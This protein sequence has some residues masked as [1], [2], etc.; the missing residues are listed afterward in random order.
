MESDCNT[1]LLEDGIAIIGMACRFPGAKDYNQ[2][3]Q[4]LEQGVNSISEVPSWRWEVEKHYSPDPHEQNK[5]ISKWGG[6]VE[7]IEKFDAEFFG[8]S[9]REAERVDPQHR[10]MLELSWSCIE[11][12]GYSPSQLSGS[13]VGV[14]IGACNYDSILL[15]NQDRENIQG[16]SGTG[17]WT[18]MIPNRISS[19][20][21]FH[22]PSVPIDTAC[23]SSLVAAHYAINAI[24]E[25]ECDVALV[26]GISVLFT[27][28][29]YVQ[30]SKLGMLSPTG[31]CRT[32]DSEADGYVRGEGAGMILLKPLR[33]AIEDGDRI[34]GT[35][36]GSAVNHGGKARTL[37]APNVYA[38]AQVLRTAYSRANISP[39]TVS[40]IESHGTGTPLGDPIE[41]NA[42]K[43]SFRQLYQQYELP[44]TEKAYCA[45][46]AVKSNI[47]HL[48]GASGIAGL[49]KILLAMQHKKLPK[50]VNYKKLNPRINLKDSPFYI[51]DE[52]QEWERLTTESGEE[53]P[54]R[55]G[56]SSFGIGG[57]NAH[58]IL[59]EAP[60][61]VRS[62]KS[63]VR[64]KKNE[65]QRQKVKRKEEIEPPLHILGLSANTEQAL[66]D[67]VVNYR[68]C[69]KTNSELEIEDICYTANT[70]RTH[71]FTA[72]L[73][74]VAETKLEL[75]EKLAAFLQEKEI[76]GTYKK[77]IQGQKPTKIAFMFTGQG[78]Q[79]TNMGASLYKTQPI[80]RQT[81][82]RCNEILKD[83]LELPL[84]DV[85][86]SEKHSAKLTETMYTQPSIFSIEYGLAK[87]WESWGIKPEWVIGHS[88][89]EYVAACV[90]GVFSLEDGLKLIA[91]R[92]RL[93]QELP[94][95]GEMVS[96]LASES[97][98]KEAIAKVSKKLPKSAI[99]IGAFN[100][101]NSIV[102]SGESQA[103][104][105][106]CEQLKAMGAK[107]KQLQVSHAFHSSLMEPML[108]EF[109][110]VAQE[111]SYNEPKI[112]LISNVTGQQI[113]DEIAKPKYW[114]EHIRQPVYFA[115]GMKSLHEQGCELFLEVGP[116]PI[117]LG[118]GRQCLPEGLG[119]WLPSL[120]PGVEEWQQMLSSLGELYAVGSEINWSGFYQDKNYQKIALPTYP[121]QRQSYWVENNQSQLKQLSPGKALH[122]LLGQK[123]ELAGID[124]QDRFESYI[125]EYSPA[126]LSHHRVFE[127]AI[128]P[129]T[130]YLE[131]AVSGGVELLKS[132]NLVLEEVF[133][134]QGLILPEK[135]VK[136]LQT[137]VTPKDGG[138]YKFEI[139]TK[140]EDQDG[141]VWM[142]HTE[143]K[144]TSATRDTS[145]TKL[146]LEKYQEECTDAIEVKDH[147]QYYQ[148]I[149][150]DYGTS[151]QGITKL[152]KGER[153]A[154]A[155]IELPTELIPEANNYHI[156]PALLDAAFQV[157]VHALETTDPN[158]TYLP[159]SIDEFKFQN[160]PGS[161]VWAIA[162]VK[163]KELK[164]DIILVDETGEVLVEV[165][166]LSLVS[167]TASA[168]LRTLKP[169]LS[170]WYYQINWKEK[171]LEPVTE[172]ENGKWLILAPNPQ[173]ADLVETALKQKQQECI[174]IVAGDELKLPNSQNGKKAKNSPQ[175]QLLLQKYTN[176]TG[177][178]NL[179]GVDEEEILE[180]E[181]AQE[182][183]C[184]STLQ[185]VQ[186]ISQNQGTSRPSLWLVTRGTQNVLATRDVVQPQY[187]S[188]WGLG[189]VIALEYPDLS[190][191]RIDLDP[192]S[193]LDENLNN[194]VAELLSPPE[195]EQIAIRQG[196]RYVARLQQQSRQNSATQTSK[197]SEPVQLKIPEYGLLE[198]LD[199]QPMQ[200]RHPAANEVEIQV[201]AVGLNFRDVLNALGMLKDYYAQ[202]L[203]ITGAEQLTFGFES[204]GTIVAVGEDV[205]QWQV[206]DE[207]M[208]TLL[209]DGFS[210]FITVK[211]DLVMAKPKAMS[212]SEAATLPLTFLTAYYGLQHLAKIQPGERILIHSAAGGV[213]QAAVQIAL[214]AGA[215]IFAT[216]SPG[217]WDFLKSLG[218]KNIMNSRT[219]EFAEQIMEM[220]GGKGVDVVLN[221]LNGDF[222]D[223]SMEVLATN[224]RFV[225]IG[226]IGIWDEEQVKQKRPD[227]KYFPFDLGDVAK[228]QPSLIPQL[229]DRLGQEW[230]KGNL[231]SLPHKVFESTEI[232]EAFRYMQQAKHIGKVVVSMPEQN[233]QLSIQSNATY[234]ITGGL[235][236]LGLEIAQWMVEEGAPYLVLTSRRAPSETVQEKIKQLE[237]TGAVIKVALGDISTEK[238]VANIFKE[239]SES[240]PPLKGII[241]A[242]GV[243]EDGL[244][245]SLTWQQFTKVMAPKVTGTWHLH[246]LTKHLPLDFFVCFSSIASLLGNPG[247]GNYAAA[248]SFMDTLAHYRR[249]LGL[250][251]LS[252]NWGPW[253]KVGMAANL[254]GNGQNRLE[255]IGLRAIEPEHGMQALGELLLGKSSQVGVFPL[256]WPNYTKQLPNG[257]NKSFLENFTSSVGAIREQVATVKGESFLEKIK[258]TSVEEQNQLLLSFLENK[259]AHLLGIKDGQID[260]EKPLT[261]MGLDSLMAV[262]LRNLIQRELEVDIPVPTLIEGISIT[263]IAELVTQSLLLEQ[264][265]S[266]TASLTEEITEDDMEE[267][268]L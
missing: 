35:I 187:G 126:Y 25:S 71:A 139:Y 12:A 222:I 191:Q 42:L 1:S 257:F 233:G 116:K 153:Q 125:A 50:I 124:N 194:L 240:L 106:V 217:K 225:E 131:I 174:C 215:E 172:V 37:T 56:V 103:I 46:G 180:I 54:R 22:G 164:G 176:L 144:I 77:I 57:V 265:S 32:F 21:N 98:V 61:E 162:E 120:R 252:I 64:S 267:I 243:L 121:F 248:N 112:P 15:M 91:I 210:S 84:L 7:G 43:R 260:N 18:C 152:W 60:L 51:L 211:S 55:A 245:E 148:G 182:Q 214:A 184:G 226:K 53:I 247:Q 36:K 78:S 23:S 41:I 66:Y 161:Q 99:D 133:I 155:K 8:I 179:V 74:I 122:P 108:A 45:L 250:P 205:E 20:F 159:I 251:G 235:G 5:S 266:T 160:H 143:G 127:Q 70:G 193:T 186:A 224:G 246:L 67:L 167:T 166:G 100:G 96:V 97:E 79:Y 47:G 114:V 29:T 118:M 213:G 188:L 190:C 183:G 82:D 59:E 17:T 151:F 110:K 117:L 146:A 255:A 92:A 258:S 134:K 158:L 86:F 239:I 177:V 80:F 227:I 228:A 38:Q 264:V 145:A 254:N 13:Q 218:I 129:A 137:I 197:V 89:G 147:Y 185:L 123:L 202:H 198:N 150:I 163:E 229:S 234:L 204:T 171:P 207:V 140:S 3:W 138:S 102:I 132:Q 253:G 263:Q 9:P 241:H 212:Y 256:N 231:H 19:F 244:L 81:L 206:G 157:I 76:S 93:M 105:S 24:K 62:Q 136:R 10:I 178:V 95:G 34:Y 261:M 28:T 170:N 238:D 208:A 68:D 49:I 115:K 52:T 104:A 216:A 58:V 26:G 156:H 94:A 199:W 130:G 189:R 2:F 119:L 101:P 109:E 220:T 219:L 87:L 196:V 237:D 111:I 30:M 230:E 168:L 165:K 173:I 221:S 6:L 88:V 181:T 262:E 223:K 259:I 40:F 128:F 192:Q 75:Q 232:R 63:E 135:E 113:S 142:L 39:N 72:R 27:L 14:F 83:Y 209:N 90:A 85:L 33:K 169:N 242:A 141:S 203:G 175:Y 149:G 44:K 236:A 107:T 69:I 201:K 268:T 195:E 31:Q 154:I 73:A 16:H 11:D 4:N 249:S 200:R 48:E 65:S